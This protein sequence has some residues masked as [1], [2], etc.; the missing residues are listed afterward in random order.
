MDFIEIFSLAITTIS[1]FLTLLTILIHLKLREMLNHPGQL[2]FLQCL[3]QLIVDLHWYTSI[4]E[5]SL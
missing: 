3:F 2:V 4:N 5:L 1:L